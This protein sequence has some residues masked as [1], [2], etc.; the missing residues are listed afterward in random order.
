M[1]QSRVIVGD[2]TSVLWWA[3]MFGGNVVIN[4]D[5]F[6]YHGGEE[7]RSYPDLIHY[8]DNL[9]KIP[10]EPLANGYKEIFFGLQL[11]FYG[12]SKYG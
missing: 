2:V 3:A 7:L 11:L 9:K 4:L 8:V 12:G 5:I 6:D 1:V 10:I